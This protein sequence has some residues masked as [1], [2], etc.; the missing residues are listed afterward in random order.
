MSQFN[1]GP[2]AAAVIAALGLAFS[3][4][5]AS[6]GA[7]TAATGEFSKQFTQ[8]SAAVGTTLTSVLPDVVITTAVATQSGDEMTITLGGTAGAQFAATTGGGVGT[9]ACAGA[10]GGTWTYISGTSTTRLFRSGGAN[11]AGACTLSGSTLTNAS[12]G[13]ATA[14]QTI[15]ASASVSRGASVV[16]SAPAVTQATVVDQFTAVVALAFNGQIDYAANDGRGFVDALADATTGVDDTTG[17][18]TLVVTLGNRAATTIDDAALDA[19]VGATIVINGDFSALNNTVSGVADGCANPGVANGNNITVTR[20]TGGTAI[21]TLSA[22]TCDSITINLTAAEV[23]TVVADAS[24]RIAI[25]FVANQGSATRNDIKWQAFTGSAS[26][27][28]TVASS[29]VVQGETETTFAPGAHTA[30]GANVF[31]PYM[32]VGTNISQ[33]LQLA[34]NSARTGTVTMTARN[35][36]GVQ[37]TSANMGGRVSI[38]ANRITDLGSML[39]SGIANCYSTGSHKLFIIVTADVPDTAV[40]LYSSYNVSGNRVAVVN[41]SNGRVTGANDGSGLGGG[42]TSR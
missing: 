42:N 22:T 36:A 9:L 24:A 11:A 28:W 6:A 34:N 26:F 15:N 19:S 1:K 17:T 25:T 16:D 32:P 12:L 38:S 8:R 13:A 2:I 21:G 10:G 35:Q 3:V 39:A 33:V 4:N 40:E 31:V 23:A 20:V 29:A 14:G 7:V 41:S 30:S 27:N 5:E 18:D 37:C